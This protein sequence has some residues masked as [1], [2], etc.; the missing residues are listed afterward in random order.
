MN[1]Q[2]QHFYEFGPFRL[3][4]MKVGGAEPDEI[5]AMRQPLRRADGKVVLDDCLMVCW[6]RKREDI[7]GLKP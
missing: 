1:H 3:E 7:F 2:P 5:A 6:S 4:A